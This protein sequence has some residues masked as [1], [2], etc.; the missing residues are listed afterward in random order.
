[1]K[2]EPVEPRIVT[3][4]DRPEAGQKVSHAAASCFAGLSS[5]S[6]GFPVNGG[7]ERLIAY[8]S[9]GSAVI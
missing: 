9:R 4:S 8:A 2:S 5:D 6:V 3:R 7:R 1:M